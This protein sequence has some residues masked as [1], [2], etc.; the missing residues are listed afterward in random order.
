MNK[1]LPH[2]DPVF[3][4]PAFKDNYI[5]AIRTGPDSI[6][7]VDP[8]DAQPVLAVLAERQWTLSAI[9]I[10]HHHW[11]HTGGIAELCARYPVPVYGPASEDIDG[12][13]QPLSEGDRVQLQTLETLQVLAVPGHTRGHIAYF[14]QGMLFCGD[15]LFSGGCGR[16]FEGDAPTMFESLQKLAA[17]PGETR[18]YCTHEYTQANLGF[19][20]KVEPTNQALKT[21]MED[22]A[23]WRQAGLATLPSTLA[24]EKAI[25]PFLRVEQT[26]VKAA[27][28]AFNEGPCDTA[29]QV[30]AALRR[31]KDMS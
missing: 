23:R 31:F 29:V 5:W 8:G 14:G 27:A 6:A 17:L 4:I 26:A 12:I 13:T 2:Q 30:F 10:T 1:S 3:A 25:N 7:V 16:L 22:V 28:E 11:D 19:A 21:Y 9:L 24:K 15:T 18:V 20:W